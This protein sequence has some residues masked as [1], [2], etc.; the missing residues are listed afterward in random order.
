MKYEFDHVH[1][2]S[3]DPKKTADWYVEAFNFQIIADFVR[4]FGDRFIQCKTENGTQVNISNARTGEKLGP[5]DASAHLGLEHF[6]FRVSNLDEELARLDNLGA[7]VVLG[8]LEIPAGRI[9]FIQAPDDVRIE[10]IEVK[11]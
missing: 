11:Q 1:L 2:K 7:P 4:S 9:V 6:G 10:L 3:E 8:P 5:G